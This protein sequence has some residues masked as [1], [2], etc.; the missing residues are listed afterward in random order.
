MKDKIYAWLIY[1]HF[2]ELPGI[3]LV[4]SFTKAL[5]WVR[6]SS[7]FSFI[8]IL[9]LNLEK[10]TIL[11]YIIFQYSTHLKPPFL[12]QFNYFN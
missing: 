5:A 6:I 8:Q 10:Y 1:L 11:H 2:Y 3:I 4:E 9:N 7:I 12:A